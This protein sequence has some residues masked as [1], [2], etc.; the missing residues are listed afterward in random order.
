MKG[1]LAGYLRRR[2]GVHT[3][4]LVAFFT[5]LMQ[6][7]ELMDMTTDVLERGLGVKGLVYYAALRVPSEIL[8]ALPLAALLGA[9]WAF[10]NLARNH[11]M[12]AIRTSGVNLKQ[13]IVY[14]LPVPLIVALAQL[15]LAQLVVP[16]TEAALQSW[17]VATAPSDETPKPTWIST[18]GGSLSYLAA[19][20]DGR[21]LTGVR[22]YLRGEDKLLSARMS[23]RT[24]EW[25][26]GDWHLQDVEHLEVVRGRAPYSSEPSRTWKT[27]LHP[28]DV[29]RAEIARP[30]LSSTMLID[31][32]G[33]ERAASQPLSY[34]HTALYRSVVAPLGPFVMLL[35]ALPAARGLPRRNDGGA[36][37]LV[38][39]GLGLGFLLCD[40]LMAALGTSGRVHASA[41]ALAAPALFCAIGLLQLHFSERR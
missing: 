25:A 29:R 24:A 34:Y 36:A 39:L 13:I 5:A 28:E 2:V 23:A 37:L 18:S 30:K 11:E 38:A 19:S 32:I 40:G 41:A 33:G 10:H 22:I 8:L 12:I 35:L 21:R 1:S 14:L 31:V 3:I 27:N 9:M 4:M 20:P 26:E 15:G 16:E 17:W 6:V 7:L